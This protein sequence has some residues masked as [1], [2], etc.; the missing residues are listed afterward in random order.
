MS[1]TCLLPLVVREA[2]KSGCSPVGSRSTATTR[3]FGARG[4]SACDRLSPG[5]LPEVA[6]AQA[7]TNSVASTSNSG[8]FIGN[9]AP[10]MAAIIGVG[11]GQGASGA[12]GPLP[13][14]ED[15]A[16][17]VGREGRNGPLQRGN[18]GG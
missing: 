2:L 16:A 17:G 7:D 18:V 9:I 3:F 5:G 10:T 4:A 13:D 6:G 11:R 15:A 8:V 14:L 1:S 12:P